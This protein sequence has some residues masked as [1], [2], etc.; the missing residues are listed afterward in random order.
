MSELQD[1]A[2][3]V[4][5]Q[6]DHTVRRGHVPR[7]RPGARPSVM[8]HTITWSFVRTPSL[9]LGGEAIRF[10]RSIA[11]SCLRRRPASEL[12]RM[13]RVLFTA[14]SCEARALE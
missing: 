13:T 11:Q 6:V 10:A 14:W 3:D 8:P 7:V 2:E 5:R 12:I 1:H 9:R 4:I